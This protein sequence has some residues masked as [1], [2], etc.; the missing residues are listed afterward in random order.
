MAHKNVTEEKLFTGLHLW[1]AYVL[2]HNL[3]AQNQCNEFEFSY[4]NL[5][6]P[7]KTNLLIVCPETHLISTLAAESHQPDSVTLQNS[8]LTLEI[9]IFFGKYVFRL[10]FAQCHTFKNRP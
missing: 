5:L 3:P 10:S 8:S 6:C 9:K 2:L 1:I 4:T 7:S